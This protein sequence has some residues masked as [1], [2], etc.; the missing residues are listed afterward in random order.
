MRLSIRHDTRIYKSSEVQEVSKTGVGVSVRARKYVRQ[1]APNT[2][3]M[4]NAELNEMVAGEFAKGEP[5]HRFRLR[6]GEIAEIRRS[7]NFYYIAVMRGRG[8]ANVR[9]DIIV[10]Q[11]SYKQVTDEEEKKRR[12]QHGWGVR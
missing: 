9:Y 3:H 7:V 5:V 8:T 2:A 11:P 1:Y 12:L 6:S 4:S 10:I